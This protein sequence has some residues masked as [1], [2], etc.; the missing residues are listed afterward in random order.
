MQST[1]GGPQCGRARL[2]SVR[3]IAILFAAVIVLGAAE[4]ILV[5][6]ADLA[7]HL[8]DKPAI[9][10]VGPNF[11]YRGKHIPGSL[12]AGPG[13]RA[14]G[15]DLLK[16]AVANLPRDREIVLYCGCC[17]WDRCPN[18]QPSVDLL[19]QMGFTHVRALHLP[20]N[21]K[22]NW[23]DKGFPVEEGSAGAK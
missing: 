13:S 6:P 8:S 22:T 12:Y 9:F 10:H 15:L 16:K 2:R 3:P 23:I 14:E 7:A 19:K 4:M 11:L 1:R 17:P 21:F 18:V 5:K 20:D